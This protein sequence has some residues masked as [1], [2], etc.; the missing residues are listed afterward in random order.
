MNA[1]FFSMSALLRK[2][3]PVKRYLL[4]LSTALLLTSVTA[5]TGTDADVTHGSS[6]SSPGT[7]DAP[8]TTPSYYAASPDS[9]GFID[10]VGTE[11]VIE[12]ETVTTDCINKDDPVKWMAWRI[13]NDKRAVGWGRLNG[14]EVVKIEL[15][16]P[17]ETSEGERVFSKVS[18]D[19]NQVYR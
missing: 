9:I 10:C 12:P 11:P 5:C 8:T 19:G 14:Q 7:E 2:P 17:I 4:G 18:L 1:G 6:S 15:S 3:P 13:W 16:Q